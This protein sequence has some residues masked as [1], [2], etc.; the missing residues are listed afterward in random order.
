MLTITC[1]ESTAASIA[2]YDT[3][4]ISMSHADWLAEGCPTI[5]DT[6][7]FDASGSG[8]AFASALAD[9]RYLVV[10]EFEHDGW[11]LLS[12]TQVGSS[13]ADDALGAAGMADEAEVAEY[14]EANG[15][16]YAYD[17]PGGQDGDEPVDMT[18]IPG[19]RRDTYAPSMRLIAN[20]VR[21]HGMSLK[22][23]AAGVSA[24][25]GRIGVHAMS[26]DVVLEWLVGDEQ[27]R[28]VDDS[29]IVEIGDEG[30]P[31]RL[32]GETSG[33][34]KVGDTSKLSIS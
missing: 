21:E 26:D 12:F 2:I 19:V 18:L 1:D 8:S 16:D 30:E 9:A 15:D 6:V 34:P 11:H 7:M 17:A 25:E 22:Q 28:P 23:I 4:E 5:G 33:F 13:E 32:P 29:V 14:A 24:L 10:D 31:V 27:E 20:L 3:C